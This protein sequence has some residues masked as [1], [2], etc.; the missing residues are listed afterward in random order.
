MPQYLP[1]EGSPT[2]AITDPERSHTIGWEDLDAR[3]SS[4]SPA[5]INDGSMLYTS[6]EKDSAFALST[7]AMRAFFG[8]SQAQAPWK[9]AEDV[10]ASPEGQ[11]EPITYEVSYADQDY[12]RI[13]EANNKL[14]QFRSRL[15]KVPSHVS[16]SSIIGNLSS[17]TPESLGSSDDDI[18]SLMGL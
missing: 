5:A 7:A 13:N 3:E 4:H 9:W 15:P 12:R 1:D 16:T 2:Y 11:P 14:T 17:S 18:L 8:V 6:K 10:Q